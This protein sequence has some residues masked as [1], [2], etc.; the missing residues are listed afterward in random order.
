MTGFLPLL[1]LRIRRDATQLTLWIVG[2]AALAGLSYVG[3]TGSYGTEQDRAALLAAAVANPVILL[4]RGLPSGAGEGAFLGF[5]ILPF[6][7]MLAAFMSSFLAVRHTRTEEE[8]G[9]AELVGAT[10]AGRIAPLAATVAH[11]VLAN[12][13]LAVLCTLAL[14]A[15]GLGMRGA[16][17]SGLATAAAGVAFFALTLLAAQLV[18]TSRSANAAGVWMIVVTFVL[19]GMGNAA[20]TPST[21]AT[22]IESG[23]LAWVSP[24]G[25]IENTRPYAS[26]D[27][28]PLA[29][30]IG[31]LVLGLGAAFALQAGRD[32]GG[33][34]LPERRGRARASVALGS[35]L[36]LAWRLSRGAVLGWAVGGLL[37]GVLATRLSAVLDQVSTEIPSVAQ[38]TEALARGGSLEQA[39]VVI[40]FTMLGVLASCC[41]VQAVCRARQEE[42]HGTAEPVLSAAVGRVRWLEAY[43]VVAALGMVATVAAGMVGALAGIASLPE[44][45]WSLTETV[46]VT[47][48]GQVLAA[49]VFLAVTA[50]VFVLVP[51]VTVPVGWAL[52]VVGML[53]GLF[54]PLFGFPEWLVD[55]SPIAVAPTVAGDSVELRGAVWLGVAVVA[56]VGG[57]LVLMRRRELA[58]AD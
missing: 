36:G 15:T 37:T 56:G 17:T 46:V 12:L 18:R 9:R 41:A 30:C 22:R 50:V 43:L 42:V 58:P 3:V 40:F 33:S 53:L 47:A 7:A 26:D 39:A 45:D 5:L 49:G 13:A 28:A 52:V 6:L 27:L 35:G 57:A 20:G 31:V 21:D 14:L 32:V 54:G 55:V 8:Q 10:A 29:L 38:L 19:S 34:L 23:W 2:T 24:F 16:I 25:W 48:G 11:A 1:A 4:F 44:P 51:R